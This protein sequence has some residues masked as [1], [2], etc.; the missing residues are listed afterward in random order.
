M[1]RGKFT[2]SH[3]LKF[4]EQRGVENLFPKSTVSFAITNCSKMT[5]LLLG[6]F[7]YVT[8]L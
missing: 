1:I 5:K 6:T 7:L 3:K 8:H 4:Y 2:A